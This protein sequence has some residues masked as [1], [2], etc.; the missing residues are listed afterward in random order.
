[1]ATDYRLDLL[2][3]IQ[4]G[5]QLGQQRLARQDRLAQ[6]ERQIRQE[7][8]LLEAN[9]QEALRRAAIDAQTL[10]LNEDK[11][12]F[13]KA[14]HDA[15]IALKRNEF[16]RQQWIDLLNATEPRKEPTQSIYY[17]DP[18]TG[19]KIGLQVP[20]SQFQSVY[21][22]LPKPQPKG[23]L[24]DVD[25]VVSRDSEG[26]PKERV[27]RKMTKAE[28]DAY[29]KSQQAPA[30]TNAAPTNIIGTWNPKSGFIRT[31]K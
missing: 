1:M 8:L 29:V 19:A 10:K 24:I 12:A 5:L 2:S 31:T 6:Q 26:R 30:P 22:S 11:L 23:E 14:K 16:E 25:V 20:Q 28:Y 4:V 17:D 13:D 7:A 15:E 21:N 27:R 3:P 18:A 9:K